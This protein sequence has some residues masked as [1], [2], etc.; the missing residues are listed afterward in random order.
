[1]PLLECDGIIEEEVRSVS[2]DIWEVIPGEVLIKRFRDI[3]Q[4]E[5]NLAGQGLG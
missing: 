5:G 3:G 1:M 2:Q 4:Q